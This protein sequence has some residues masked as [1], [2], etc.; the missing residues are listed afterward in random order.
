MNPYVLE[1]ITKTKKKNQQIDIII[2]I[3]LREN[4]DEINTNTA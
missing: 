1:F 2:T 4:Y 3:K